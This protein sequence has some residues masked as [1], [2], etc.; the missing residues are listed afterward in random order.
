MNNQIDI[1]IYQRQIV[2][3]KKQ[4]MRCKDEYYNICFVR[5][6]LVGLVEGKVTA[7][8]A[9]YYFLL[10]SVIDI[11]KWPTPCIT[12]IFISYLILL[13]SN[14]LLTISHFKLKN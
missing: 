1:I 3:R 12:L 2:R 6:I 9:F 11:N 13:N 14:S 7:L 4:N 5:Y 8:L 10:V